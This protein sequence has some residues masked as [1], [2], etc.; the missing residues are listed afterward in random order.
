MIPAGSLIWP[1]VL[2]A[3]KWVF[4]LLLGWA[5]SKSREPTQPTPP[6]QP[7]I[8]P[9]TQPE[10]NGT[11]PAEPVKPVV[12]TAHDTTSAELAGVAAQSINQA[13]VTTT[14]AL[15][16]REAAVNAQ[17]LDELAVTV[18]NVYQVTSTNKPSGS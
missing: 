18:N 15:A 6:A 12:V 8:D 2:R 7:P 3:L 1:F 17:D 16:A 4:N 10:N 9:P 14:A 13:H 11:I 5:V